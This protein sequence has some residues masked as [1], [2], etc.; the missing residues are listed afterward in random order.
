MEGKAYVVEDVETVKFHAE[1]VAL[2]PL[3]GLS[4]SCI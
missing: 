2:A 3:D 4:H 1:V